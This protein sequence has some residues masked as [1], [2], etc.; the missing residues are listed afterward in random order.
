M[1]VRTLLLVVGILLIVSAALA[2]PPNVILKSGH[3]P[4]SKG[5]IY[6]WFSSGDN[7]GPVKLSFSGPWDF[8]KGPKTQHYNTTIVEA[9]TALNGD[10]F[11]DATIAYNEVLGTERSFSFYKKTAK[12]MLWYGMSSSLSDDN[13]KIS[14]PL[15]DLPFPA[16]VGKTVSQ[17]MNFQ[18]DTDKVTV[19]SKLKV[20]GKGTVITGAGTLNDA[21]MVQAKVSYEGKS[22][23]FYW[24]YAPFVG[25]VAEVDSLPNETNE[26]FTTAARIE[27]LGGC[28]VP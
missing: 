28:K 11:P 19:V 12:G 15:M 18:F 20:V 4:C 26:L 8:T 1:R 16:K 14:P 24:W 22:F 5:I 9:S 25:M 23:L 21:V 7:G 17:T 2:A 27:W 13:F 6:T 3:I 10:K